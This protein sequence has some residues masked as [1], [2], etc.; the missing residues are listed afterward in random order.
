V[1]FYSADSK[2]NYGTE[3]YD[4]P[5]SLRI[6]AVKLFSFSSSF[7]GL[8]CQPFLYEK[9]IEEGHNIG[10]IIF[11]GVII[12]FFTFVTPFLFHYIGKR[13]VRKIYYNEEKDEY[14][15]LTYNFFA[16]DKL[17]RFYHYES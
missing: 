10:V 16:R 3:I 6:R 5:L 14:T 11:S 7:M 8:A 2:N 9:I 17:V 4:G 12:Q 1:R 15:A 13:Y